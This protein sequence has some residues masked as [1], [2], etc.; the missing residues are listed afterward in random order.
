MTVDPT[1]LAEQGWTTAT[2]FDAGTAA[3]LRDLWA[4]LGVPDDQA[5]FTSNIHTDRLTARAVD[6]DLKGA[7]GPALAEALPGLEPFL[8]AFIS[9]GAHS[10]SVGLHP[11]WTY[12]DERR[13]RTTLVWCPLVDTDGDNGTLHVVPGSHRWVHGLRGSGDFPSAVDGVEDLLLAQAVTVPLRV[14]QAIVYDAALLHGSSPNT[15]GRPRPVAAVALAPV[16][17]QLVHFHRGDDGVTAG[18]A[19]DESWYTVQPFGRP[20]AGYPDYE[21]WDEP[22]RPVRA[23]EILATP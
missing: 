18:H 3:R 16:G 1:A 13:H 2:L 7:L 11:D 15:S 5:Y 6:Q 4:G 10:G 22:L 19:I 14:G 8:A 9:K 20:P 21:V 12:T 17:A 23:E